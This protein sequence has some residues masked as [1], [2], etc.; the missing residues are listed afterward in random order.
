MVSVVLPTLG[1]KEGLER[2][3]KS[4]EKLNYPKDRIETIVIE[5]EPRLGVPRRVW[6]GYQKA[7]GD[8]ICFAAN[9]IEFTPNS[10]LIAVSDYMKTGKRLIAFDT[11]V[12]NEFGY[13]CEHFIIHRSLVEQLG[14]IFSFKLKH[15]AA[16]TL[17]WDKASKLG[18][19]YQSKGFVHH[20][21]YSRI[22]SGIEMDDINKLVVGDIESDRAIYAKELKKLGV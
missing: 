17:L 6:E 15:F 22:G 14:E 1:R 3:L 4:I 21:H 8:I 5:D 10:L 11:G 20:Y 13:I 7:T 2:C 16:D 9:D 12:R 19:A 18:D